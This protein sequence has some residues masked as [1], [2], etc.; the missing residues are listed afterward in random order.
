MV[1]TTLRG[2]LFPGRY[3]AAAESRLSGP[4][5]VTVHDPCC[6]LGGLGFCSKLEAKDIILPTENWI[7]TKGDPEEIDED[8]WKTA[9]PYGGRIGSHVQ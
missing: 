8:F 4:L 2:G 9:D 3:L 7:I 1:L 6:T 5:V